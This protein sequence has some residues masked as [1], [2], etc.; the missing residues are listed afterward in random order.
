MEWLRSPRAV[1]PLYGIFA[2][3]IVFLFDDYGVTN[4]EDG[5]RLYGNAVIAWYYTGFEN[6]IA[7]QYANVHYYGGFFEVVAQLVTLP[8]LFAGYTGIF[9]VRHLVNALFGLVGLVFVGRMARLL[10]GPRAAFLAVLFLLLTPRYFGHSFNNPKDLP[11]AVLQ[12]VALYYLFRIYKEAPHV[13]WKLWV[14]FALCLGSALAVRIGAVLLG[15]YA[16]LLLCLPPGRMLLGAGGVSALTRPWFAFFVRGGLAAVLAF[17]WMLLFW[18]YAQLS[19]FTAP[20]ESLELMSRFPWDRVTFFNGKEYLAGTLPWYY[21]PAWIFM[22]LPEFY[23]CALLAG[24]LIARNRIRTMRLE[25]AAPLVVLAAFVFVPLLLSIVLG[26][27][28]YDGMRHFLFVLPAFAVLS[29]LALDRFWSEWSGLRLKRVMAGIVAGFCAL[30][31]YD[32]VDLHPFQTVYF[33]RV[34]AGGLPYAAQRFETDYWGNGYR[35]AA[36]WIEAN[37]KDP[38]PEDPVRILSCDAFLPLEYHFN[39]ANF[40][41]D[42]RELVRRYMLLDRSP[43]SKFLF[44]DLE[45]PYRMY[46]FDWISR[47]DLFITTTRF[48]C[49]RRVRGRVIHTIDRKGVPLVY[50]MEPAGPIAPGLKDVIQNQPLFR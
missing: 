8:A 17:A 41:R 25:T 31:A 11:F 32:T 6:K 22:T 29:A 21:I 45:S 44:R 40:A 30:A 16:V 49:H 18:P 48:H 34:I 1:W 47:P 42:E 15:V 35:S 37:Y 46:E 24:L 14:A 2:V 5:L 3:C 20:L 26:S 23:F 4:D 19:P 9:E 33:N 28:L 50:I 36:E 13:S 12:I 39:E 7:L 38:T 27:V 10:G 43:L